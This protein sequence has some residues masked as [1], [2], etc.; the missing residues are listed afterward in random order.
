M[1]VQMCKERWLIL[2]PILCAALCSAQQ[3][4]DKP[5]LGAA[6]ARVS[7]GNDSARLPVKRVVLYKNGVGYFEH[8]ARVDGNQ[9]L[10]IDFTTSQLNDVLKSLTVVDLGEGRISSIRYNSI[11]PLDE[12]LRALRLP[13]GEQITRSDFLSALRG[14]RVEVRSKAETATGR[15]LSVEQEDR[16]NDSGATY[17]RLLDYYRRWRD[18]ELRARCSRLCATG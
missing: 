9:E 18:E 4:T 14:S 3:K 5:K 7:E 8:S 2:L 12:R 1:E 13:F 11:A 15:L 10:G 6:V 17:H 16:T